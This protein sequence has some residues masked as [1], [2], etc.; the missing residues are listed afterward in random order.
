MSNKLNKRI[1]AD[2]SPK[3]AEE[4]KKLGKITEKVEA[5]EQLSLRKVEKANGLG[6]WASNLP[7]VDVNVITDGEIQI[8]NPAKDGGKPKP[9]KGS[10]GDTPSPAE[11]VPKG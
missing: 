6:I 4:S 3:Q 1:P 10:K 11:E 8:S 7:N 5:K 9:K 2:P